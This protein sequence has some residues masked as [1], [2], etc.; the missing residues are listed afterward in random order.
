MSIEHEQIAVAGEGHLSVAPDV[1]RLNAGVEVHGESAA[2]AFT[3]ARAAAARL[4]AALRGAGVA[5]DDLR[6]TELSLGPVYE[7]Y[8]QVSGYRAAQGVEAVIRDLSRADQVIDT[9]AGVG[10]EARLDGVAFELSDP[11]RALAEARERA[12]HDA[13]AKAV[14]YAR[15]A[16]R[17]LGRVVSVTETPDEAVVP[18]ARAVTFADGG[19]STSPGRQTL[20]VGVRVVYAFA[21]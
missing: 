7:T 17:P 6:T 13:A 18:M 16:G 2:G 14:H 5:E 15:L 8:G 11:S 1:M 10:E 19:A 12:F 20:S 4:A 21:E 9:V 3:G